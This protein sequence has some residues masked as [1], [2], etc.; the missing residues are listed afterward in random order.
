MRRRDAFDT[1][2][3]QYEATRPDYPEA[4]V[5]RVLARAAGADRLL[6]IGCG[7]AIATMPYARRGYRVLCLEPGA[8]LAAVARRKLAPYPEVELVETDF[9]GWREEPHAFD[10]VYAAQAWHHVDP[11]VRY[12]KAHRVL[13]PD[14]TLAI[15]WHA[16]VADFGEGQEAYRKWLP[17]WTGSPSPTIDERIARS[18]ASLEGSGFFRLLETH[19]YSW[20]RRYT[21]DEYLALLATYSDHILLPPETRQ[22]LFDGLRHCIER[23]GGTC[24][25][26][27]ETVLFLAAIR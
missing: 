24:E 14:G 26:Q 6:E 8:N 18:R 7:T 1:V 10:L 11:E 5:D 9:E 2:A 25:R 16:T 13:K 17:G 20:T 19:R 4:L 21:A 15:Y 27:Y 22:G 23:M 3:E 12:R